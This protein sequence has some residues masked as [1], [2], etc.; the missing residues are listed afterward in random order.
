MG[1]TDVEDCLLDLEA[2]IRA[3]AEEGAAFQGRVEGVAKTQT[4]D[5]NADVVTEADYWVQ[6][7]L[8]EVF[9]A[10]PLVGCQVVA[11]ESSPEL[12]ALCSP[13]AGESEY[14]LFLDPIDGTRRFLE[15]LPYFA[16]IVSLRH[17]HRPL[18]TFCYYPKLNWW[19]RL[20]GEQGW[21]FSASVPLAL[22]VEPH[23]VVFTTGRPE[24]DYADW[25]D[26]LPA[27]WTWANGS[28]LHPCGSKLLYLSGSVAGY[29]CSKPNLYDGLMI[30]HYARVRG[31]R[32]HENQ[33]DLQ[34]PMDLGV[35]Q[36]TPRGLH[37]RGRYLCVQV[38]S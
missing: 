16:T 18:Y 37:V 19:V 34:T 15:G 6:R 17:R 7:R 1:I 28:S 23:Q 24:T 20:L 22:P 11:E 33:E 14:Q 25:K 31:H 3:I 21:E 32:I 5:W 13:F 10:T 36:R 4:G 12:E 8:L 27:D 30:Y 38:T 26:L 35:W 9:A 29:A 2:T